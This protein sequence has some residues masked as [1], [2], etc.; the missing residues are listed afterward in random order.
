MLQIGETTSKHLFVNFA[1]LNVAIFVTPANF[2]RVV[3]FI[4]FSGTKFQLFI[5]HIQS[6]TSIVLKGKKVWFYVNRFIAQM[7]R[8][9]NLGFSL[10]IQ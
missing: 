6:R 8:I 5:A 3:I 4:R 2:D 1:D 10:S 7:N 9:L